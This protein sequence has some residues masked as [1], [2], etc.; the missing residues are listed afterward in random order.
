MRNTM[1]ANLMKE[2]RS[3]RSPTGDALAR[4][5]TSGFSLLEITIAIATAAVVF[6]AA[7]T[8]LSALA[9]GARETTLQYALIDRI[10]RARELIHRDLQMVDPIGTDEYG[11][12]FIGLRSSGGTNNVLWFRKLE[13]ATVNAGGGVDLVFGDP[14]EYRLDGDRNLVR[15]ESGRSEVIADSITALSFAISPRRVVSVFFTLEA[16]R[17][18]DALTEDVV[19]R[20]VPR[21]FQS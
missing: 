16:G 10:Q 1:R 7:G 12:P 14:I 17:G 19:L 5:R 3:R 21:N 20:V 4:S 8:S 6:G 15:V 13:G 11:N 9:S 2:A 18:A